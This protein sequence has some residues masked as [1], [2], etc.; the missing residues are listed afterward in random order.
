[1][2]KLFLLLVICILGS[3]SFTDMLQRIYGVEAIVSK[4]KQDRDDFLDII[5]QLSEI[6]KYSYC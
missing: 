3:K 2:K 1:M 4:D 5:K 6:F